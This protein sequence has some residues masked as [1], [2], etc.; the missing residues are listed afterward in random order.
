[1]GDNKNFVKDITN[2]EEDFAKWYTDIVLKAELADYTNVK[3]FIAIRPYGYAIWEN[4]QAYADKRFKEE[5]AARE[6]GDD[7]AGMMDEDFINAL[8]YGMPPTGGLGIGIDRLVMLLILLVH[9]MD[10]FHLK[11][12]VLY[13][14]HHLV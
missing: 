3:G 2:I 6:N 4:I 9:N 12:Y 10:V 5:I 13:L 8:E 7:E 14:F 1:M 11:L